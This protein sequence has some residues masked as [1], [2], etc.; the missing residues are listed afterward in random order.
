MSADLH[1]GLT[2]TAF[3]HS[4]R[5]L[6]PCPL[7]T[8]LSPPSPGILHTLQM[9]LS[10]GSLLFVTHWLLTAPTLPARWAGVSP[11][12]G[13]LSPLSLTAGIAIA[14][15]AAKFS[16]HL[17]GFGAW[18]VAAVGCLL[19]LLGAVGGV[20]G[21][22]L[23]ALA[24]PSLWVVLSRNTVNVYP[25]MGTAIAALVHVV[26]ALWSAML[27]AYGNVPGALFL[28]G[29]A[30]VLMVVALGGVALGLGRGPPL[31]AEDRRLL[32][33]MLGAWKAGRPSW[34]SGV[35]GRKVRARRDHHSLS[36]PCTF[37]CLE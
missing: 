7:L 35:P 14:A 36:V 28:R 16:K 8:Q 23:L 19:L 9:G 18:G 12:W 3:I 31:S 24:A 34:G 17:H 13:V 26:L 29:S 30:P 11:W 1:A 2:S 33:A 20:L 22:A 25:G 15:E 6:L 4:N 27:V 5:S 10:L 37:V 21:G 32:G